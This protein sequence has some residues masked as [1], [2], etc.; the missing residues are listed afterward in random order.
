MKNKFLMGVAV[1]A[2]I[3]SALHLAPIKSDTL[4]YTQL[5]GMPITMGMLAPGS[6]AIAPSYIG[7]GTLGGSTGS[8]TVNMPAHVADD[9]L[10][11]VIETANEAPP[12]TPT[13][14]TPVL[15]LGAGPPFDVTATGQWVYYRRAVDAATPSP[16]T[17]DSGQHNIAMI[18]VFRG[19]I[20]SGNPVDTSASSVITAPNGTFPAVT[21]TVTPTLVVMISVYAAD[22]TAAIN[23]AYA[24][25]NLSNITEQ[26][27]SGDLSGNGGGIAL[28]T[29]DCTITT[30]IGVTTFTLAV[31]STHVSSTIVLKGNP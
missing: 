2:L 20:S 3:I 21:P 31:S 24:N 9:I 7:K 12:S 14:W 6:S 8:V 30:N 13:N 26:Q 5:L 25:A 27:D 15:N 28:A 16:A 22:S 1:A 23:S 11:L 10:L 4:K 18:F 17:G 29:A 19:C